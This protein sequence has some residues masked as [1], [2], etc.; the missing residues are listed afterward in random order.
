MVDRKCGEAVLR[1]APVYVPGVL[2]CSP[3]VQAGDR[4]VVSMADEPMT[5]GTVLGSDHDKGSL[6]ARESLFLGVG[7]VAMGA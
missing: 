6:D 5:R 1:G 2:G 7:V 4:V 3:Q